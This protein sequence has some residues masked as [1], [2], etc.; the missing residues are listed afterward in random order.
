MPVPRLFLSSASNLTSRVIPEGLTD[1]TLPET[2][3]HI[4]LSGSHRQ[5]RHAH[6]VYLPHNKSSFTKMEWLPVPIADA[7]SFSITYCYLQSISPFSATVLTHHNYSPPNNQYSACR[8]LTPLP[9]VPLHARKYAI[10]RIEN[11][12]IILF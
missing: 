8:Y 1:T 3:F 2:S 12:T 11:N 4:L 7:A 9:P 10:S 5:L 6:Q